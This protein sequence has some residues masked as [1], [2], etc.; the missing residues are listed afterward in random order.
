MTKP[1]NGK[2]AEKESQGRQSSKRCRPWLVEIL[3]GRL[4]LVFLYFRHFH[5]PNLERQTEQGDESVRIVMI[6][7]ISG[8]EGSKGFTVQAVGGGGSRLD[9][10]ALVEFELHLSGDIFLG[11]L[12]K[13]LNGFP[14]RGEPFALID[15]RIVPPGVS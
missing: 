3:R 14:E 10:I 11:G 5:S 13:C 4:F 1:Q 12:H 2:A 9:D 7:E 8:G 6:V 15:I